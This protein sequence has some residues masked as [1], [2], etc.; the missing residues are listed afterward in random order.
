MS[1]PDAPKPPDPNQTASAQTATNIGTAYA[2]NLM[3]QVNQVTPD[4]S[5]T[6]AQTGSTTWR[7]PL[8]GKKY[9]I[10]QFTATQALSPEAQAIR[11]QTLGAQ[12]G[13]GQAANRMAGNLA[14]SHANAANFDTQAVED[15]LSQLASQRLDPRFAQ[16]QEQ[17]AVRLGNQGLQPGSAAW[18]REMEQFGQTKNDAYNQLALTGRQ[19][20]L[21]E[22]LTQRNQPINEIAALLSGSQVSNPM[23]QMANPAQMPTVDYAGLTNANFNQKYANYQ[24]QLNNWNQIAGGLMGMG[25]AGIGAF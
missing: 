11:D 18:Q 10:P 24:T 25:S 19:Q 23:T 20:A 6:Y 16:E 12:L 21:S 22:L 2:N 7:D 5:L 13:L 9:K 15:H 17:L 8:S 4:G 3:G 1:K 14:T